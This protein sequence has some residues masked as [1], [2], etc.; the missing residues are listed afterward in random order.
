MQTVLESCDLMLVIIDKDWTGR[1]AGAPP[2]LCG[3]A[4]TVVAIAAE[5]IKT[6]AMRVFQWN[7]TPPFYVA[8]KS[9]NMVCGF[10]LRRGRGLHGTYMACDKFADHLFKIARPKIR[11]D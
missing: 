9:T 11:G 10:R 4:A 8:H 2:C 1:A 5:T 3:C 7:M 6:V